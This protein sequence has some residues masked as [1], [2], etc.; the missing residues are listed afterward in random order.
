MRYIPKKS[1][2]IHLDANYQTLVIRRGRNV[3]PSEFINFQKNGYSILG[4]YFPHHYIDTSNLDIDETSKAI[5]NIIIN[6]D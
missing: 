5:F 6:N 2:L 4:K 3:E 1:I